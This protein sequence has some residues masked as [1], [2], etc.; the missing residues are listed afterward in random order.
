MSGD[1]STPTLI[2]ETVGEKF[3]EFYKLK[4]NSTYQ[5]GLNCWNFKSE[6]M[7]TKNWLDFTMFLLEP[8]IKKIWPAIDEVNCIFDDLGYH[9]TTDSDN[10]IM[11]K[12]VNFVESWMINGE[13][14]KKTYIVFLPVELEN[15]RQSF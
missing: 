9:Y 13:I 10:P 3:A 2:Q 15:E 11:L 1:F 4:C 5:T 12:G 7:I 6:I 14:Y 8:K